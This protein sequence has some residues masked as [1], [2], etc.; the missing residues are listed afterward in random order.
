MTHWAQRLRIEKQR[1]K[2]ARYVT[3]GKNVKNNFFYSRQ[4]N[5]S[6]RAFLDFNTSFFSLFFWYLRR[7]SNLKPNRSW[8]EAMLNWETSTKRQ[9]QCEQRA[10]VLREPTLKVYVKLFNVF[11]CTPTF[12]FGAGGVV[13]FLDL[14]S[15]CFFVSFNFVFCFFVFS[16]DVNDQPVLGGC[17]ESESEQNFLIQNIRLS[18][19][20]S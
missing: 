3:L 5:D 8:A 9:R 12:F 14:S 16:C 18:Q 11:A 13:E 1:S 15:C 17:F 4:P 6:R 2:C 7:D 10:N 19:V 20:M